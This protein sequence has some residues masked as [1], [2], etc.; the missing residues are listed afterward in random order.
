MRLAKVQ[1]LTEWWQGCA[2]KRGNT[3]QSKGFAR[4]DAL[5]ELAKRLEC[6]VSRRFPLLLRSLLG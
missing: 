5:T 4:S 1:R 3:A 6:G 2:K